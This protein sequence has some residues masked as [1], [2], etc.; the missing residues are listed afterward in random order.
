MADLSLP[1]FVGTDLNGVKRTLRLLN[2]H[3]HEFSVP[4]D[5]AALDL[6][7]ARAERYTLFILLLRSKES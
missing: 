3:I 7:Q 5:E 1:T 6:A 4:I 2:R